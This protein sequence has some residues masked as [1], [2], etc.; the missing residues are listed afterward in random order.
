MG[1]VVPSVTEFQ[2][3]KSHT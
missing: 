1:R 2:D 3:G